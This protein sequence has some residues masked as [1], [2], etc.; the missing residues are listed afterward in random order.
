M[1]QFD[2]VNFL[3]AKLD[4][5]DEKFKQTLAE[6][7][8][9]FRKVISVPEHQHV[10]DA[11][12]L[13]KT[14]NVSG[15]AVVDADGILHGNISASDIR[16]DKDFSVD[17]LI[18]FCWQPVLAIIQERKAHADAKG[19]AYP[20]SVRSTSSLQEVIDIMTSNRIHR[21]YIVDDHKKLQG[22]VSLAD[23]LRVF[24]PRESV[25]H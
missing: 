2:I 16:L 19:A 23:L 22:V 11:F 7:K 14:H 13:I 18:E 12:R 8:L 6:L 17:S 10:G 24:H 5:T 21:V 4:K 3:N 1:T 25:R 9:G 15:V 20:I